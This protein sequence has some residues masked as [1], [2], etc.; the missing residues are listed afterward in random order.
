MRKRLKQRVR[1]FAFG[2]VVF[3]AFLIAPACS[4]DT[5]PTPVVAR[6][7]AITGV[8]HGPVW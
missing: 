4:V 7:V 1:A 5:S 6:I 2:A 8:S 3:V